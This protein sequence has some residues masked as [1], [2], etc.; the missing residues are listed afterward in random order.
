MA[1]QVICLNGK[2][3][4]C[5]SLIATDETDYAEASE[6]RA[7]LARYLIGAKLDEAQKLSWLV[8]TNTAPLSQVSWTFLS[9]GLGAYRFFYLNI[10]LYNGATEYDKEIVVSEIITQY[11]NI[12]YHTASAKIYKAIGTEFTGIEPS[13]TVGWEDYWEEYIG[14]LKDLISNTT[15]TTFI[16][17]DISTCTYE[18][19][20]KDEMVKQVNEELC[21]KCV[22]QEDLYK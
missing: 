8:F 12:I 1:D 2:Y 6:T 9:G 20:I 10:P 18:A 21:G 3:Q 7:D 15:L 11:A 13:V 17:E 14:E 16:Q 22:T 4:D 5:S 19:K